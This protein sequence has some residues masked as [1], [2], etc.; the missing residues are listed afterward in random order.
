MADKLATLIRLHTWRLDEQR[1]AL[2]DA[3]RALDSLQLQSRALDAEIAAEQQAAAAAPAE[4]GLAYACYALSAVERRAACRKAIS[5]AETDIAI[6]REKVQACYRELRTLEL[7]QDNRRQ[8]AKAEA[9]RRE[10]LMLDEIALL[11]RSR[12]TL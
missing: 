8:R 7:A 9:A 10:G 6:H 12:H 2:A 5:G 3:L 4:V 11:A 1:R